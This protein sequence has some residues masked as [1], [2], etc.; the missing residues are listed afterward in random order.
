MQISTRILN[1]PIPEDE[2]YQMVND[3]LVSFEQFADITCSDGRLHGVITDC[4]QCGMTIN[5]CLRSG[6]WRGLLS[7]HSLVESRLGYN[8]TDRYH[9]ETMDW[10]GS[11]RIA[12]QWPG[13]E[14]VNVR[15]VYEDVEG[16]GPF[17]ISPYLIEDLELYDSGEGFCYAVVDGDLVG[18]PL[19]INFRGPN[20]NVYQTQTRV[21]YPR[22]NEDGDWLI[23]MLHRPAAP[24][25]AD[26][27]NVQHCKYVALEVPAPPTCSD[28]EIVPVYPGTTQIIHQAKPFETLANGGRKYWFYVWSL[29]DPAFEQEGAD[30]TKGEFYK[31]LTTV[32]FKCVREVEAPAEATF[33]KECGCGFENTTDE[34]TLEIVDNNLG[35]LR[36]CRDDDRRCRCSHKR[37]ARIKYYYKT[38]P[39]VLNQNPDLFSI[40]DAI[41]HYVAANLPLSSCGCDVQEGFIKVAQSAY[42]DI[43]INPITGAEHHLLKY[44]NLHGHLVFAERLSNMKT[45]SKLIQV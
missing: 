1:D 28:G 21:G 27:V 29:I 38:S 19:Q 25:C 8:L 31:L 32:E 6:I 41:A 35:V 5:S 17:T 24:A 36:V 12:T 22:K 13:V 3:L 2:L 43:R 37:P 20:G 15:L 18:N 7:A 30:L 45:F 11:P 44:G 23:A 42:T 16:F 33:Y 34:V 39:K 10:S 26:P 4:D 14:K 40:Q 9:V